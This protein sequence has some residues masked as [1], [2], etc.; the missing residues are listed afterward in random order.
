[1]NLFAAFRDDI[2][3]IIDRIVPG[4]DTARVTA[5]PPREAAHGDVAT[6]A[7]MVLAKAASMKPRDLAEKLAAELRQLPAVTDVEIAGPGFINLRLA[8]AFWAERLADIVAAGPAYGA[9]A[10][11]NHRVN[12][13]YVSA[14]PTGPMHIGH[15]RGAVVGDALASLL[16]KAGFDV[17]REYYINDAG[18]QIDVLARSALLRYRE[19]LGEE[20]GD[21]PE[22][23]YPGEYLKPLG[24]LL[25]DRFGPELKAKDEAECLAII[26]PIAVDAMMD[27]IRDDLAALG[28]VHDVFTSERGLVEGGKVDAAL[29]FLEERGEVYTGILEPPKGKVLDDWEPR[30]QVLFRATGF[31]DDVDRPLKKSD[32]SWTYFASDI[33]YHQD[34]FRRGF[35]DQIDIWGADHGGYVK[36]MQAA[37]KA[38]SEGQGALDVKLCQMVN[39]LKGGQPYKMSKRA[40]TFVTLRDLVEAVGKDVV[41]FIMLTRK[42]D[43][44]L[45]FDLDKVL[46]QSRDNP[47]FYVQYAHARC[48]SVTR[49]GAALWPDQDLS[50]QALAKAALGRLTDPAELGLIK[51]L[52]GWPRLVESAAEAHEPHRVAFYLTEVAAGFHGLWN[53]GKDDVQL[54]FLLEED[55]ELSVARLALLKA[56]AAVIASGLAIFGVEPVEEMR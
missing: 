26:R 5:E 24:Q 30:P 43:A 16:A 33:A 31:G 55:R 36:R 18:G 46:E 47:V 12:V 48:Q 51:L 35:A 29:S 50:G 3:A 27:M 38:V 15:A 7:A 37:V 8:D 25:A 45:D 13:E 39:L 49:H 44:H 32:G 53:K 23:L 14:N 4:L 17:T 6:N 11:K 20:I 19:A 34:K 42:N 2:V 56:V 9:G 21:I 54:R 40:G 28:V 41:R 1:M 10:P 22:G 52:A